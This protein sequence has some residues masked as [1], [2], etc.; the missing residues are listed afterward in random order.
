MGRSGEGFGPR[1]RRSIVQAERGLQV[2]TA[3]GHVIP[4]AEELVHCSRQPLG[5]F[6][7]RGRLEPVESSSQVVVVL[8]QSIGPVAGIRTQ[9]ARLGLFGERQEM[10]GVAVTQLLGLARL[11]EPFG[12][13]FA[14]CPQHPEALVGLAEEAL[15]HE[16]L[17]RVEIGLANLLR[18]IESAALAEDGEAA[19]EEPL[20]G[21]Q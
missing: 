4:R 15:V 8:L 18:G 11:L 3:F 19:E 16:R 17:E 20:L 1:C 9:Q 13:V 2:P 7:V 14:D 21:C 12:R 6:A 5:T 10:V